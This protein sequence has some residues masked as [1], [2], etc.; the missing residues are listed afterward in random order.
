ML[1]LTKRGFVMKKRRGNVIRY[2]AIGTCIKA[3]T[4]AFLIALIIKLLVGI[5]ILTKTQ[6]NFMVSKQLRLTTIFL[7]PIFSLKKSIFIPRRFLS[8]HIWPRLFGQEFF[9]VFAIRFQV[10][11][12]KNIIGKE[13]KEKTV[14]IVTHNEEFVQ[15]AN[16]VL[17]VS[18]NG[19]VKKLEMK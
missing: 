1:P 11:K 16:K 14:I 17:R 4:Y 5:W 10:E 18:T 7:P 15:L 3:L 9:S 12:L 19:A 13:M 2:E 8:L 6:N